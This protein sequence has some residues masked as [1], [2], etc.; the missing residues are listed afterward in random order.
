M[1]PCS[2]SRHRVVEGR[3][4]SL[5]LLV[6]CL[7]A[8]R[9]A[10]SA[11]SLPAQT[12]P[13]CALRAPDSGEIAAAVRAYLTAVTPWKE[14]EI[15][16]VSLWHPEGVQ[17]PAGQAA[18]RVASRA[19]PAAFDSMWLPLE[20]SCGGKA[21]AP[22]WVRAEVRVRA[23]VARLTARVPYRG[24][25]RAGDLEEAV[26]EIRDA[27]ADYLRTVEQA[28]GMTARRALVPGD[29]VNASWVEGGELVRF[30][31]TVRLV[32]QRGGI[33]VSV[34]ARALQCGRMGDPVRV[35]NLQSNRAL[36]AMVTGPGEV[37]VF[38]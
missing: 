16:V 22:F 21:F 37:T 33:R 2:S 25:L 3:T 23:R 14:E 13:P 5:L 17:V 15:E 27:R 18:L 1:L 26:V 38:D 29:L 20:S 24:V 6:F 11:V 4:R 8:L 30:G 35:R 19:R 28:A 12:E 32:T 10:G 31:D 7:A 34:P 36:K 9:L